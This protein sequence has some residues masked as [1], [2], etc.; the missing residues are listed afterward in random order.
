M[1]LFWDLNWINIF[2]RI[3]ATTYLLC[4]SFFSFSQSSAHSQIPRKP[5]GLSVVKMPQLPENLPVSLDKNEAYQFAYPFAVSIGLD[6]ISAQEHNDT[7]YYA[8]DIVSQGAYS[9][10][11]MFENVFFSDHAYLCVYGR[12]SSDF[13]RYTKNE[14]RFSDVLPTA[15]V[16]G[17][18][19]F[20]RFVEPKNSELKSA[21]TITQVAHDF[22]NEYSKEAELKSTNSSSCNVDINCPEGQEWQI[23]KRAVCKLVIQGITACTGTLVNN[24]S[25]DYTPYVLTANH[26]ISNQTKAMKTVFYFDYEN[27]TCGERNEKTPKTISGSSLVATSP[28]GKVDFS[29]VKLSQT[30]PKSYNPYYAGWNTSD[31]VAKGTV[32]IHHPKGDVKK[33]SVDEAK[34]TTVTFKT[35]TMTYAADSHWKIASWEVGTTEAG[36]SGSS[37]FD[38]NHLVIGSL[39]GGEATCESS[40][41]DFFSKLSRAW[42]YYDV[43]TAQL[44]PWLDPLNLGVTRCSGFDPYQIAENVYTN[45]LTTDTLC[46]FSFGN[47]V[48]GEWSSANEMGWTAIAERCVLR[49]SIYGIVFSGKIDSNVPLSDIRFCIWTGTKSPE[50]EV[51]SVEMDETMV[52][53]SANVYVKLPQPIDIQGFC[54]IGYIIR[55]NSRAFTGY[56]TESQFDGNVYVRHPISWVSTDSLGFPAHLAML[57]HVTE[58]PDTLQTYGYEKPFFANSL[59][60]SVV[61]KYTEELF[62]VDSLGGIRKNTQFMQVS[63]SFVENWAGP[64]DVGMNCFSNKM[65]VQKPI[66]LRDIKLA[67]AEVPDNKGYTDVCVWNADFSKEL[68]RK[69][70]ANSEL[71]PHYFNQISLDTVLY[72]DSSFA[73]GICFNSTTYESNISMLQYSDSEATVDG[74][75]YANES[76]LSYREYGVP[77]L[78]GMQ[79]IVAKSQYHYSSGDGSILQYPISWVS[80]QHI[81]DKAILVVYPSVCTSAVNLLL[82]Q[83]VCSSV[84]VHIYNVRGEVKSHDI[85]YMQNGVFSIPM[86]DLPSGVYMIQI[87]AADQIFW[88]KV[89]HLKK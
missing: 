62:G 17:D 48:S 83:A 89:I 37:L 31:D 75:F 74:Y 68:V 73:Y 78:I 63:N 79:P 84:E 77:Y 60:D 42:D 21:W 43:S 69:T 71:K 10:N 14:A 13:Q 44:K 16:R 86:Q 50:T 61:V 55:N 45:V 2:K 20:V 81:S 72:V 59:T 34:P 29:L 32:C 27:V 1:C 58:R 65:S 24:T 54:W 23:E 4:M 36:S 38:A 3:L 8:L 87:R 64:N 41:N 85:Y 11:L 88:N 19:V 33:I 56:M 70:I 15:L 49:K 12:D 6:D 76:W 30:P 25:K 26:C 5:I 39:S 18:T 47:S 7:V 52:Q 9:L 67:V 53:D 57:A 82:Q 28:D 80:R 66:Y 40:V 22:T 46:R 51:F 35:K